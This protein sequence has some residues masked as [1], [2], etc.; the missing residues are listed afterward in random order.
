[1]TYKSQYGEEEGLRDRLEQWAERMS[2]DKN[3]PWAGLGVIADLKAA[4]L[5]MDTVEGIMGAPQ[6][7]PRQA[8]LAQIREN[9]VPGDR[10]CVAAPAPKLEF[11]L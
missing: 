10:N 1:M 4:V 11:D 5:Y 2:M 6:P 7:D 9:M 3:L 8:H